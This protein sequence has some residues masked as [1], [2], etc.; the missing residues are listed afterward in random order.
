MSSDPQI[1]PRLFA[2]SLPPRTQSYT[3]AAPPHPTAGHPYYFAQQPQQQQ[4]QQ[5]A[6]PALSQHAPHALGALDPTLQQTSPTGPEDEHDDD[7]H[8]DDDG[9][10]MH[11]LHLC[12]GSALTMQH[13][14]DA[15]I[16]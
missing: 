7:E 5:Q 9:Y 10:A 3:A 12:R 1:D 8:D 6:P 2:A 14:R 4:Q 11:A 13:S 15:R 16:G